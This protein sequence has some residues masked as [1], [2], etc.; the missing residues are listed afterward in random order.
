MAHIK[1]I[2]PFHNEKICN[3]NLLKA[4]AT[5]D[6]KLSVSYADIEAIA[7]RTNS[8]I[9]AATNSTLQKI[10]AAEKEGVDA[11]VIN[12]MAEMATDTML[13]VA[14]IPLVALPKTAF[15]TAALLSRKFSI[16]SSTQQGYDLQVKLI[17]QYGLEKQFASFRHVNFLAGEDYATPENI[18]ALTNECIKVIEEDHAG[19]IVFGSGRIAGLAETIKKTLLEKGYDIPLIEPLP[20]AIQYAKLLVNLKL[21]QS[22]VDFPNS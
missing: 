4:Y 6:I 19:A 5:K 10:I 7:L 3:S 8:E 14:N 20:L 21:K 12:L 13:E 16:V 17:Q 9:S 2:L 22:K 18:I 15:Y 1:V 11:I